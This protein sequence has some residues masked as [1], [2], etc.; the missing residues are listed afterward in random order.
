MLYAQVRSAYPF[1]LRVA[2]LPDDLSFLSRNCHLHAIQAN[3]FWTMVSGK[4]TRTVRQPKSLAPVMTVRADDLL[5]AYE[6]GI[7]CTDHKRFTCRCILLLMT[8]DYPGQG[9]HS[10]MTHKGRCYCHWCTN[11]SARDN[12]IQ[13]SV[14]GGYKRYPGIQM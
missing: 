4:P 1:T 14:H 8:G 12:A 3:E 7:P 5:A 13:R 9:L 2:Q 10:E 11:E 6:K